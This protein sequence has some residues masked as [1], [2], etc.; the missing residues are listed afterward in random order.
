MNRKRLAALL[1]RLLLGA[2]LARRLWIALSGRDGRPR[3]D[4]ASCSQGART[5]FVS[6]PSF[7]SRPA[8]AAVVSSGGRCD[9]RLE[10]PGWKGP[11][12]VSSTVIGLGSEVELRPRTSS[13][14]RT[15]RLLVT[16][17]RQ[18]I[19]RPCQRRAGHDQLAVWATY[20]GGGLGPVLGSA[21]CRSVRAA[22]S[23]GAVMWDGLRWSAR[24]R[25]CIA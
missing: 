8:P 15:R 10:P 1:L 14:T 2:H 21:A 12:S 16:T 24:Q 22:C 4:P 19:I 7:C 25:G 11:Y 13:S 3:H 6:R 5:P 17:R 9:V 23:Y 20:L 18:P